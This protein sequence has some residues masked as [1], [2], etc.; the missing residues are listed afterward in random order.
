MHSGIYFESLINIKTMHIDIVCNFI[1][2]HK[3]ELNMKFCKNVFQYYI[4]DESML[5]NVTFNMHTKTQ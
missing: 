5:F 1:H 2:Y 4:Y 3:E